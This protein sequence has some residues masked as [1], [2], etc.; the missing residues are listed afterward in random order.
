MKKFIFIIKFV[1][2]LSLVILSFAV[3]YY[4]FYYNQVYEWESSVLKFNR[5]I[6]II[7]F[8]L[9]FYILFFLINS[10]FYNLFFVLVII[11]GALLWIILYLLDF[12]KI[13]LSF[14]NLSTIRTS[15][16][17]L[18]ICIISPG[19]TLYIMKYIKNH[20]NQN[21]KGKVFRN[22][23]IHE[24]F[25]GI[26]FVIIA[27][28][29]LMIRYLLI[30]YEVFREEL[31]IFLAITIVLLYLFL[32]SGSFLIFRDRR[33]VI[34]FKFIEQRE[35]INNND[36][37]TVF[38]PITADSIQFFKSPKLLCYPLGILVNSFSVNMLMHGT[39]FLPE[40]IFDLKNETVVLIGFIL[41]IIS[42]GIIG[43]DWYRLFAKIY[44]RLYQE[45]EQVLN[46][47]RIEI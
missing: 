39:L 36:T 20:S 16:A 30:Q 11:S 42:S 26:I 9:F 10:K 46:S 27:F 25:A 17:I 41:C 14:W 32:F 19:F 8:V 33:D 44:P 15:A 31:R 29:L 47:L 45:V 23:H 18:G 3:L 38:S 28:L 2:L 21:D 43:V 37:G 34:K 5:M 13:N 40:K 7:Y 24:G 1:I 22:Y 6:T 35:I 12:F 4:F